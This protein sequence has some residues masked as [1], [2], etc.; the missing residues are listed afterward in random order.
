LH[1]TAAA[2]RV[3]AD[4][5]KEVEL[6]KKLV[7]YIRNRAAIEQRVNNSPQSAEII[8]RC[9]I[10]AENVIKLGEI[11]YSL[12]FVQTATCPTEELRKDII[13]KL[14]KTRIRSEGWG[15]FLDNDTVV[16]LPT[17]YAVRGLFKVGADVE[18]PKAYIYNRLYQS[19]SNTG[20]APVIN[21]IEQILCLF[22]LAFTQTGR[23]KYTKADLFKIFKAIGNVADLLLSQD[24]EQNVEYFH[25]S[26]NFYVRLPWQL[27]LIALTAHF[28]PFRFASSAVQNRL[29]QILSAVEGGGFKY[30]Y[31]GN[32]VSSRTNAILYD[33]FTLVINDIQGKWQHG[34]YKFIDTL[35]NAVGA[36]WIRYAAVI[37]AAFMMVSSMYE[38]WGAK[39]KFA[40]LA[41]NLISSFLIWILSLRKDR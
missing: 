12:S 39:A 34:V 21:S 2:L 9:D 28:S 25:G 18:G 13:K 38:W 11:L 36:P 10:D 15:Y 26:D 29:E 37:T 41:P 35:R 5:A 14:D 20:N 8:A 32:L 6:V 4:D 24:I 19:L 16:L 7:G 17:A 40:E 22:T 31:S 30:P 33:T 3:L 23:E 27:Y 1:G